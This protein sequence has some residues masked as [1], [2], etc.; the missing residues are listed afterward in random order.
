MRFQRLFL[1]TAHRP[2]GVPWQRD[3]RGVPILIEG[4]VDRPF[5]RTMV[6]GKVAVIVIVMM[7]MGFGHCSA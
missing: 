4:H 3:G 5:I 1:D 6:R 2:R 7:L